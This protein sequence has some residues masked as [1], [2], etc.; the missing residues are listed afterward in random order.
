[1]S[2]SS[3]V[4]VNSGIDFETFEDFSKLNFRK[5]FKSVL[6]NTVLMVIFLF[7][8]NILLN[9]LFRVNFQQ[10]LNNLIYFFFFLAAVLFF[11]FFRQKPKIQY[12]KLFKNSDITYEYNFLKDS[13]KIN[14]DNTGIKSNVNL[15]Y[16]SLSLVS[17]TQNGFFIY[18]E[19]KNM[20]MLSKKDLDKK[21]LAEIRNIFKE[22]LQDRFEMV[23]KL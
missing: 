21:V 23:T 9:F 6:R 22:K 3:I 4:T 13:L 17:E 19:E 16:D 11:V 12:R 15:S 18:S 14:V 2:G 7:S 8:T 10:F 1:M 5:N 20:F